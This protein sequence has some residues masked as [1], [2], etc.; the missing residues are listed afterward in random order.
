[1]VF[2]TPYWAGPLDGPPV[3]ARREQLWHPH[4]CLCRL[5]RRGPQHQ[6]GGAIFVPHPLDR[7]AVEDEGPPQEP[8][9]E[10]KVDYNQIF[11]VPSP[12]RRLDVPLNQ[13]TP[14]FKVSIRFLAAISSF[15]HYFCRITGVILRLNT[16]FQSSYSTMPWTSRQVVGVWLVVAL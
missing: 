16:K 6:L 13:R 11:L 4:P 15:N 5:V 2:N 12:K 9:V 7:V 14:T 8:K 1:M 3:L 10:L